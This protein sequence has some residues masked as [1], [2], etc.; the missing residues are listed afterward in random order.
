MIVLEYLLKL[1]DSCFVVSE[2]FD[3]LDVLVLCW[4]FGVDEVDLVILYCWIEG[5]GV[6]WGLDVV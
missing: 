4:C 1:F 2:I 5:V 3:L 6:C